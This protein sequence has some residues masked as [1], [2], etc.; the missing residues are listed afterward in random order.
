MGATLIRV[1][2]NYNFLTLKNNKSYSRCIEK[3]L[4]MIAWQLIT[5]ASSFKQLKGEN[6][7]DRLQDMLTTVSQ[8][9]SSCGHYHQSL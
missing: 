5:S 4:N 1:I 8:N 7:I 9:R 6:H 2:N 3:H